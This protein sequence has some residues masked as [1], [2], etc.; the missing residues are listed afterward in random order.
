MHDMRLLAA[1]ARRLVHAV[2]AAQP[3]RPMYVK[4]KLVWPCN[5]R[6]GMCQHWRERERHGLSTRAWLDVIEELADLGCEKLHLTGGEPTLHPDL[7]TL[8]ARASGRGMRVSMTSN[9]TLIDAARAQRLTDAGLARINISLDSAD[10]AIHELI[11][12]QRSCFDKTTAAIEHMSRR[13]PAGRV[14]LNVLVMAVNFRGLP[15][16][17]ALAATLGA[18][19]LHLI[20]VDAQESDL[21]GL[22]GTEIAEFN[23]KVAPLLAKLGRRYGV[24][25]RRAA[26]Y[27]FGRGRQA[28]VSGQA[29]GYARG[30]YRTHRCYAPFAHALIDHAGG[31]RPCCM[32][33]RETILGNLNEASFTSIWHGKTFTNLRRAAP[34]LLPACQSCD[35]FLQ[36]NKRIQAII[37][38]GPWRLRWLEWQHR[39]WR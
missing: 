7:E 24:L 23:A 1:E 22:N 8:I 39:H 11:R 4:I 38:S 13:L 2:K 3:F 37:D 26:A 33:S 6:C 15:N 35:M 10:P 36:S 25:S 18:A 5:L 34:P 29:G 27:P 16:L 31:V 21:R 9:G 12:G 30:Y 28:I 19:R 17:P 14:R 32:A 20:P